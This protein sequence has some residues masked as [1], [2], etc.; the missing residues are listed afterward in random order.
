MMNWISLF[1]PQKKILSINDSPR[2]IIANHRDYRK[3]FP[4]HYEPE[5][6]EANRRWR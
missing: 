5:N 3:G 1:L 2:M 6:R 4:K